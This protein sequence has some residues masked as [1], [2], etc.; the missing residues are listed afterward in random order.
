MVE[1]RGYIVRVAGERAEIE[2]IRQTTCG[3]CE[4]RS[5]CGGGVLGSLFGRRQHRVWLENQVAGSPGDQ[6]VVGIEERDFVTTSLVAY[7]IPLLTLF[8]GAIAA[9][10]LWPSNVQ[11]EIPAVLGG[12]TGFGLGVFALRSW[13]DNP[14]RSQTLRILRKEPITAPVVELS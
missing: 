7:L 3:S 11:G 12:I 13:Q 8:L 4:A 2:F 1:E 6:V 5:A 10:A 9:D 14:A